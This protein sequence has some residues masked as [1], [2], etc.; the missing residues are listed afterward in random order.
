MMLN[1]DMAM[2]FKQN[3]AMADCMKKAE[4]VGGTDKRAVKRALMK[5]T[6]ECR[7]QFSGRSTRDTL[8]GIK[9]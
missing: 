5:A 9:A 2:V 1:T 4:A 7:N 8:P 3:N 6:A